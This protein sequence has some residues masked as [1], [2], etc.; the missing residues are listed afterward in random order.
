MNT[1]SGKDRQEKPVVL[2]VDGD[3]ER[4]FR[5]SVYLM[6]LEYHV[7]SVG[8]AEEALA[9]AGL[10]VP[11]IVVTGLRLPRMSSLDLLHR[12]KQDPRIR[13]VPV[14]VYTATGDA[15]RTIFEQAGCA[16]YIM[17][18]DD[19]NALYEAVQ[20]ATEPAPRHFVR[21]STWLDVTMAGPG[22]AQAALVTAISEQGMF[23]N[24]TQPLPYG[25]TAEFTLSLPKLSRGIPI[26]GMVL[27]SHGGGGNKITG[28][29][30]KFLKL[31]PED[32]RL[33]K[34]FIREK[35]SEGIG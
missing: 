24:T 12:I 13:Q 9:I 19:Q 29:G 14:L 27:Y 26:T 21:L 31:G 3:I 34:T 2:V 10:T 20:K 35:L 7:F 18:T 22:G 32:G 25:T 6:R 4:R 1:G 15:S 33:I 28:M 16:G 11:L 23:V 30:V 8:S 17:Q 5:T